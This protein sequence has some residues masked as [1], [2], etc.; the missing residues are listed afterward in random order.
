M[1]RKADP[2]A[3]ARGNFV[4]P[5]RNKYPPLSS[6]FLIEPGADHDKSQYES[7]ATDQRRNHEGTIFRGLQFEI[8]DPRDILRLLRAEHRNRESDQSQK[9]QSGSGERQPTY[10]RA[11]HGNL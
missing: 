5:I 9:N 10:R 2:E 3:I 6:L 8:P 4:L 1:S 7:T 11:T